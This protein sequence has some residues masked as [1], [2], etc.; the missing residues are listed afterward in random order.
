MKERDKT[1]FWKKLGTRTGKRRES[2]P[3]STELE[4]LDQMLKEE[5]EQPK[6]DIALANEALRKIPTNLSKE[7]FQKETEK[8]RKKYPI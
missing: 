3:E 7:E 8:I 1:T 5:R 2:I 6:T 4:K